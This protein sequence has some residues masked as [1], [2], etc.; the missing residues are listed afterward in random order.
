M[1]G[2]CGSALFRVM[3]LRARDSSTIFQHT[4]ALR[5]ALRIALRQKDEVLIK[6]CDF[7]L[8][9]NG[10]VST[11]TRHFVAR[12]TKYQSIAVNLM[13]EAAQELHQ[14]RRGS[15]TALSTAWWEK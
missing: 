4:C 13:A 11:L 1:V 15:N 9:Y 14:R 5:Y 3:K 12:Q 7:F 6:I 8:P 10:V 2:V